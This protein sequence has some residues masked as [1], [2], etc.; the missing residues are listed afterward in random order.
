M[1]TIINTVAHACNE[2]VSV[3]QYRR[4]VGVFDKHWLT[5]IQ[6]SSQISLSLLLSL[7]N[8]DTVMSQFSILCLNS[9]KLQMESFSFL[10]PGVFHMLSTIGVTLLSLS[11]LG[12]NVP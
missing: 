8:Y 9:N 1:I 11:F 3:R 2:V 6:C 5:M 10:S 4:P 12:L 7:C